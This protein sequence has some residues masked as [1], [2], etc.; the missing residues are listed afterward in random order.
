VSKP[1]DGKEYYW[2]GS[3]NS[4]KEIPLP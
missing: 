1:I 3:T 2:D 4:W